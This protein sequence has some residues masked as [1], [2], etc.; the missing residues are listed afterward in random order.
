MFLD[1]NLGKNSEY[2]ITYELFDNRVATRIWERFKDQDF[3]L[4]SPDRFYG[5]GESKA[6]V[7]A[8]LIAT[9]DAIKLLRPDIVFDNMDLNHLHD[10]FANTHYELQKEKYPSQKL[11][12][13]LVTL[14]YSIHHMED[15][16]RLAKKRFTTCTYDT[17]EPL[18]DTD[19]DLFTPD[20]KQNWLYMNYPHVGKHIMAIFNDGDLAIPQ[21]QIQ[22]TSILKND[23]A[24]WF[25]TDTIAGKRYLLNLNRFLV[26]ISKK[27]PY[28]IDD[29]RLAIGKIP[30]GVL[31]HEPDLLQ[32]KKYRFIHSIKAY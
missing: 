24:G 31:T 25:D 9:V 28:T 13:L 8:K 1:I 32:I 23:L 18:L 4:V 26:K 27:L 16:N 30:L 7:E 21:D 19:Y 20:M 11:N 12:N 29:K 5:F 3:L 10:I 17:G 2:K 14:N 15:I 22:P 6:E